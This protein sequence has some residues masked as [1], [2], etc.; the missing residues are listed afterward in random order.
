LVPRKTASRLALRAAGALAA[1]AIVSVPIACSSS[2][3]VDDGNAAPDSGSNAADGASSTL[4]G[5]AHPA[6]AGHSDAAADTGAHPDDA[7]AQHETG[8]GSDAALPPDAGTTGPTGAATNLLI[9]V[10]NSCPVDV[11][12]HG[13]AQEGVLAPDNTHLVPGASQQYYGPNTWTAG[14]INA[15]LE[16]PSA[17]GNPQGQSDKVEMNFGVTNGGESINTDITYVDW[18]G[19]PSRIEAI[20]SGSDCT[21]VGCAL[22]Y[23][24]ILDGC[25]PPLL[26]GHECTSAGTFCLNPA[27]SGN[28]LCHALD[29][30]VTSC[31]SQ[32]SDCAGA[33]GST[34]ADVYACAGPFFGGNSQY[35]AAL[36][37]GVLSQPGAGTPA[38]D[39]Y[40]S[41]PFN[42]YSAWVHQ[43]CPGIYA[44]PYDD[45]GS[46]NQS[47]DHTC[48]GATRLDITWCP[49][50]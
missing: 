8:S 39:F 6:D 7:S 11:W 9:T 43:T 22:P 50:G 13:A 30:Q 48:D 2:S 40:V 24:S 41:P 25:P 12:I 32:Y 46:S 10:T 36:N 47:S 38:S 49:G 15:F 4:D 18:V 28:S 23:D 34:T 17:D 37:R 3:G 14:R 29:S 19:L 33:A 26:N 31:A 5:G 42:T 35:C 20:G 1:C 44:F 45:F 27:N 21:T 16:A